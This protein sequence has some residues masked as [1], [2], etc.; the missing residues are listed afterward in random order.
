MVLQILDRYDVKMLNK[1][2]LTQKIS[3]EVGKTHI[4]TKDEL[5]FVGIIFGR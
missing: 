3:F 2:L 5:G 1:I 4:I